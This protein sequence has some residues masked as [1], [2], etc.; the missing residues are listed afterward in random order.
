MIAFLGYRSLPH[1]RM[2]F[3]GGPHRR[4]REGQSSLRSEHSSLLQALS[5]WTVFRWW[6]NCL[7]WNKERP[8]KE[9]IGSFQSRTLKVIIISNPFSCLFF[10]RKTCGWH[11]EVPIPRPSRYRLRIRRRDGKKLGHTA[12][13]RV[14]PRVQNGYIVGDWIHFYSEMHPTL[15][16]RVWRWAPPVMAIFWWEN[17]DK[18][19]GFGTNPSKSFN[20]QI[21]N[22]F[23]GSWPSNA[24]IFASASIT[25]LK[26]RFWRSGMARSSSIVAPLLVL[27][28]VALAVPL[29]AHLGIP[30]SDEILPRLHLQKRIDPILS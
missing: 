15:F 4:E 24:A 18:A 28:S 29:A 8:L 7:S 6:K 20:V 25:D 12:W 27:A 3:G 16:G 26:H 14:R 23:C 10:R 13:M 2:T 22:R 19:S 5:G 9:W 30:R 11:A 17:D 1:W 21:P